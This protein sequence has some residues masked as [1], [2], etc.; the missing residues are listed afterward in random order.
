LSL[1]D[2]VPLIAIGGTL[3]FFYLRIIAKTSLFPVRDPR[4]IESLRLTN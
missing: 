4:L 3:G 1:L 2:F